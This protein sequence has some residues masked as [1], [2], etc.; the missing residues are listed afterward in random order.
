MK[1]AIIGTSSQEWDMAGPYIFGLLGTCVDPEHG[2][3]VFKMPPFLTVD[4][5]R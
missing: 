4:K 3:M 1:I 2:A 5:H